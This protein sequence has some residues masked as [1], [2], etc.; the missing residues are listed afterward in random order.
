MRRKRILPQ[1]RPATGGESRKRASFLPDIKP[2]AISCARIYILSK[3]MS[4]YRSHL[5]RAASSAT[6]VTSG[7]ICKIEAGT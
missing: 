5:E 1:K 7:C 6:I 4:N 2:T 3:R